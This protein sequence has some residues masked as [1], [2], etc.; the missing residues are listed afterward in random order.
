M[1][2]KAGKLRDPKINHIIMG[3]RQMAPSQSP[4]KQ[5]QHNSIAT[6][7]NFKTTQPKPPNLAGSRQQ[8]IQE[9]FRENSL[10]T[11]DEDTLSSLEEQI[12]PSETRQ[13]IKEMMSCKSPGP[14]G[15]TSVHYK[16]FTDTLMA[17]LVKASNSV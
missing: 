3:I 11:L 6:T 5:S 4:Q 2:D 10:P 9:F 15:L 7:L 16:T 8:I 13:A 14:N 17:P 12:T 1:G